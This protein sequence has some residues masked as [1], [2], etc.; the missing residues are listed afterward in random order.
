MVASRTRVDDVIG[1]GLFERSEH[2]E[3]PRELPVLVLGLGRRRR[4]PGNFVVVR[5]L[6]HWSGRSERAQGGRGATG[7][8]VTSDVE[9]EPR[10]RL[11]VASDAD[12]RRSSDRTRPGEPRAECVDTGSVRAD[13]GRGGEGGAHFTARRRVVVRFATDAF[14]QQEGESGQ[15]DADDVRL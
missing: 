11:S 9:M 4:A 12:S 15:F 5:A 1:E 3:A 8:C 13:V 10:T 6:V 7:E 14:E 2:G